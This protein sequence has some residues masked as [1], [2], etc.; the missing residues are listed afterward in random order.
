MRRA[1]AVIFVVLGTALWST[2]GIIPTSGKIVRVTVFPDRAEV[3]REA[4]VTVPAGGSQVEF[5]AIPV[6][7][8][9]DSLQVTARGV[10][11]T[12][13]AVDVRQV[14]HEAASTAEFKAA[15]EEVRRLEGEVELLNVEQSVAEEQRAFLRA[16]KAS[17]TTAQADKLAEGRPDLVTIKAV[18]DLIGTGL[19]TLGKEI[20]T[21]AGK[22][23]TLQEALQ[24]ARAKRDAL[25]REGSIHSR[26][27]AVEVEAASGGVLKFEL[28]YVVPGASWRPAYRAALDADKGLIELVS[29][30]VVVQR[31]GEDWDR[32]DL[33]LSTAAPARGV[34]P[35]Q[36]DS[37]YLSVYDPR[38]A[39]NE[40]RMRP[41]DPYSAA[42]TLAPGIADADG[43]SEALLAQT[44]SVVREAE[45]IHTAYNAAFN[46]AGKSDVVADG[47][48][49]RVTLRHESLPATLGY[50]TSPALREDVYSVATVRAPESYPLLAGPV[51]VVA[52]GTF[53]GGF[54]LNETAPGAELKLP[55]GNDNRVKV[56]RIALPQ[57]RSTEGFIG[58]DRQQ[59]FSFRLSVEN[60]RDRAVTVA[61]QDRIP[62]SQDER[63]SVKVGEA[64]TKG[65]REV[66]DRPG[67]LEWNLSLGPKEKRDITLDYAV[68]WP[69][70][71]IVPGI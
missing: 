12:I 59:S 25:R 49:H 17:T 32:V 50:V 11:A 63:I 16:L 33:T 56:K 27:A 35:P 4:S 7:V 8:E 70:E 52:G 64:T 38:M 66:A 29:E 45:V 54:T 57:T 34:E 44:P 5:A 21:R 51:R 22:Q 9:S 28:R 2:A 48:E 42:L 1:V 68:R 26:V 40:K 55:F 6:G 19:N 65:Y 24:V 36:I 62:V 43:G 18:Y 15:D 60:L 46:V 20:F 67:V 61:V 37:W 58:K 69:K 47:A 41:G 23:R 14:A 30:A 71:L 39:Q 10:A 31:S 53:L 13:G 3:T